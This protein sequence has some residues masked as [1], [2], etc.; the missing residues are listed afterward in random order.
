MYLVPLSTC[1]S[2]PGIILYNFRRRGLLT[3]LML[4][5]SFFRSFTSRSQLLFS[6]CFMSVSQM[7]FFLSLPY[8]PVF[9]V[10][11]R[12]RWFGKLVYDI[13][14]HDLVITGCFNIQKLFSIIRHILFHVCKRVRSSSSGDF[15]K[16]KFATDWF[17][18]P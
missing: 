3:E 18:S 9:F 14:L 1:I 16:T 17:F 11:L 12:R 2:S 4:P 7:Q 5:K 13:C 6:P 10:E 8:K 15:L